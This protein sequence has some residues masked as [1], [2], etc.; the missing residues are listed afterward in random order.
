MAVRAAVG[1]SGSIPCP[2]AQWAKGSHLSLYTLYVEG[3]LDS[4]T[5][6]ETS[7]ILLFGSIA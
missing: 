6:L 4:A 7:K 1:P 2:A 5:S 3:L